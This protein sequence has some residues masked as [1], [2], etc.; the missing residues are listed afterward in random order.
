MPPPGRHYRQIPQVANTSH[1]W[2]GGCF[3]TSFHLSFVSI[4]IF[5]EPVLALGTFKVFSGSWFVGSPV[6]GYCS[7]RV[8]VTPH[9]L[10]KGCKSLSWRCYGNLSVVTTTWKPRTRQ[11]YESNI[12]ITG[13]IGIIVLH[14]SQ[15]TMLC[16]WISEPLPCYPGGTPHQGD[17]WPL[18]TVH[19]TPG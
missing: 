14:T 10:L 17:L 7:C 16:T 4:F 5:V 13:I 8:L 2:S 6:P 3:P 12:S 15:V 1:L 19:T 11:K 9:W 18:Q